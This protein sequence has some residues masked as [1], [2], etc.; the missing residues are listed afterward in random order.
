VSLLS[1]DQIQRS[2]SDPD[3]QFLVED[4]ELVK[5]LRLKKA[6]SLNMATRKTEQE[7][8]RELRLQRENDRRQAQGLETIEA[9]DSAN[10]EDEMPDILLNQAAEILTDMATMTRDDQPTLSQTGH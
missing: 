10:E 8:R 9:M 5:A 7:D 4:V 6:V 3:F 2:S 1:R